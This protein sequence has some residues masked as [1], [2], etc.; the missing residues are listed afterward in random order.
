MENVP[1]SMPQKSFQFVVGMLKC[2]FII[3]KVPQNENAGNKPRQTDDPSDQ[4]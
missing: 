4:R 3:P 2:M 1:K